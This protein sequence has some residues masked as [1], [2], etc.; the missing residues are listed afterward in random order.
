MIAPAIHVTQ[1]VV[2]IGM[3]MHA[4][5]Y[6][7]RLHA[8]PLVIHVMVSA[9]HAVLILAQPFFSAVKRLMIVQSTGCSRVYHMTM[10]SLFF[11]FPVKKVMGD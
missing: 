10:D 9:L 7:Q 6:L 2:F 3:I 5:R 4:L 8:V 11:Y 1:N